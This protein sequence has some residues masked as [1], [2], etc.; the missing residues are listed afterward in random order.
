MDDNKQKI[1]VKVI[2][3]NYRKQLIDNSILTLT[4]H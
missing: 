4:I 1:F 2:Y 3:K